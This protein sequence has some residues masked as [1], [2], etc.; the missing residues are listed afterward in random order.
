MSEVVKVKA[1]TVRAVTFLPHGQ[2]CETWLPA[3]MWQVVGGCDLT[4][5]RD[6]TEYVPSLMVRK[7]I[8]M[9]SDGMWYTG[10]SAFGK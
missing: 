8:P 4:S 9:V 5:D 7:P 10:V 1:R 2:R 6:A 3:G